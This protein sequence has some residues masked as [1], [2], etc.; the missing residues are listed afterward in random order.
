MTM[1]RAMVVAAFALVLPLAAGPAAAQVVSIP[2]Q[3]PPCIKEFL[4]LRKD[5]ETK[6]K[7][8]QVVQHKATPQI[9]CKLFNSYSAAEEKMLKYAEKNSTWCGIPG[10]V[11]ASIKKGHARTLEI[12]TRVC[13]VAAEGPPRPPGPSLSDA[14]GGAIPDANNIKT[15]HG[16]FDTLTGTPLGETAK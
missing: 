16:T 8:I 5:T 6:G 9:A 14:L 11:V 13:R 4:R 2:P 7:A 3:A 12:R 10:Q 1:R 15:G